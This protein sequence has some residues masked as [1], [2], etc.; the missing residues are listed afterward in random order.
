MATST[1]TK[2]RQN[3]ADEFYTQLP[4]IE[5]EMRHYRDQFKGKS[6]LCN[7]DDPF[8]SNFFKYF[9][10]N[11]N[12]LGLRK[13]VATCYAGS[14]VMQG[15]LDLFGVPGVAESDAA[16]KKPYK[17]EITEVPDANADGATDLADVTYL[18]KNRRNV[19]TLLN[20][21]GD[22]RSRECVE[23]MKQADIVVTNPPFSLFREYVAQLIALDKKFI[24][25]GNQNAITYKDVFSLIGENKIW[26]G[27]SI[28]SGDR[29]FRV[30]DSYPLEAAG[31]R[32]DGTGAKYIRVKGVRWFTNLD[33][34]KR[35]EFMTLYCNYTPEAYPRYANYD[36]IEVSKTSEIPCD[37]D[38]AM[39]VPI[40]F[41]D[42]YNPEQFEIVGAS[43]F[44]GRPM[45]EVAPK[46][47]FVAGGVRFYLPN[48]DGTYRRLYDRIVIRRKG[49]AS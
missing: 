18:L 14:S 46:G 35:H 17:I 31:Y 47:T 4:D 34:A 38:G 26:L 48:G 6:V 24:I 28:H 21:D 37:F 20:G 42:K 40:T 11:F 36:A 2:A 16:A 5:A 49:S 19:L 27:Q 29:E 3:K 44:L 7:C 8:E 43:R 41:L 10:L 33:V 45:A 23:L 9:A 1:L 32:V 15:E 25:I 22:F 13:L 30:P 12:F 39:G